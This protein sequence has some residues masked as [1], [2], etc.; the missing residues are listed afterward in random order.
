MEHG[1]DP[2]NTPGYG[3]GGE[4]MPGA[5]GWKSTGRPDPSFRFDTRA[6]RNHGASDHFEGRHRALALDKLGAPYIPYMGFDSQLGDGAPSL[7]FPLGSEFRRDV[8]NAGRRHHPKGVKHPSMVDGI[9]RPGGDPGYSL[10]AY[11]GNRGGRIMIPPS[12]L[13]GRELVPGMG[14]LLPV[15]RKGNP[16]DTHTHMARV[17]G[18]D[19]WYEK[20][21][22]KV[23]HDD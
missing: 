16:L 20:Q 12:Y 17:P 23:T 3:G 5:G 21:G 11:M 10:G 18:G 15:D 6:N 19:R 7:H 9:L 1:Y 22:W 8:V 2:Q 4:T 14:R 13:Y